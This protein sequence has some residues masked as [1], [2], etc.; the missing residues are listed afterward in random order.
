MYNKMKENMGGEDWE[1]LE[2]KSGICIYKS[3]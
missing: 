3:R 1:L 2:N